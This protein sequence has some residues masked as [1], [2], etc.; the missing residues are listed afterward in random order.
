MKTIKNIYAWECDPFITKEYDSKDHPKKYKPRLA[1]SYDK[2]K[3]L[4]TVVI[5]Y[6]NNF[7]KEEINNTLGLEYNLLY[8][9]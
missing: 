9:Y 7:N 2:K 6:K 8:N 5:I 3:L 1:F 4:D